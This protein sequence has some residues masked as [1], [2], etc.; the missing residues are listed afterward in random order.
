MGDDGK[1]DFAPEDDLSMAEEV[2]PDWDCFARMEGVDDAPPAIRALIYE[3]GAPAL[4]ITGE[5]GAGHPGIIEMALKSRR[6]QRQIEWLRTDFVTPKVGMSM[7]DVAA[8][9]KRAAGLA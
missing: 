5:I 2:E 9:R 8:I 6:F 4:V 7:L 1:P 3:Y